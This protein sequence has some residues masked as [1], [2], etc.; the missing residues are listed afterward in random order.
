MENSLFKKEERKCCV[1][2]KKLFGRSDKVFCDIH[3]KN[4]YHAEMRKHTKTASA[5]TTKILNKNYA[6]LCVLLGENCKRFK[7][8]KLH[9][10]THGFNFQTISG[11]EK[12]T[13]G[14]KMKI[15]E[16]SWYYSKDDNIVVLRDSEQSAISPFVYKRWE[17][18]YKK[19]QTE[20]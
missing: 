8:K 10:E 6:I 7:V 2:D 20:N 3:C 4:K 12:T 15:Y 18:Q 19:L 9:L 16:F 14:Q 1:C 13:L 17:N 11:L 5:E